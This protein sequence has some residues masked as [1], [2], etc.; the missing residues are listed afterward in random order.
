M[1]L[2]GNVHF[3]SCCKRFLKSSDFHLNCSEARMS[4]CDS[5]ER[6]R[7]EAGPRSNKT[8]FKAM[9]KEIHRR[10]DMF[11]DG[12]QVAFVI[13]VRNIT[14]SPLRRINLSNLKNCVL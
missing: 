3:C 12:S 9:L 2:K 7:N 8:V 10:E 4:I 11:N 14:Y 5:C 13:R 1:G 6:L